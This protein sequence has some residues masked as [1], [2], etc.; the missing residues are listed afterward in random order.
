[1]DRKGTTMVTNWILFCQIMRI[2]KIGTDLSMCYFK[3]QKF[4]EILG[5]KLQTNINKNGN[6]ACNL[7]LHEKITFLKWPLL[8]DGKILR[9]HLIQG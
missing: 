7:L 3:H 8:G 9:K 4:F 1:M 5:F 6:K 2:R